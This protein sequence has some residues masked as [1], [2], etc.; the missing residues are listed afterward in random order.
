MVSRADHAKLALRV[1]EGI[2]QRI[3]EAD[4]LIAESFDDPMTAALAYAYLA[5]FMLE[6]L[7]AE[8]PSRTIEGAF[9]RIQ[10]LLDQ[11]Q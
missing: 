5:G 6:A 8:V 9:S 3:P 2:A 11:R 4:A 1:V 10:R 7:A